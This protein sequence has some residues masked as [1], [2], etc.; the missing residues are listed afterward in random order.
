VSIYLKS[1][2]YQE[3]SPRIKWPELAFYHFSPFRDML[4]FPTFHNIFLRIGEIVFLTPTY[5]VHGKIQPINKISELVVKD[6][7][8]RNETYQSFVNNG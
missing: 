5:T 3:I 7:E 2:G 8:Q 4:Q 1:K 6:M